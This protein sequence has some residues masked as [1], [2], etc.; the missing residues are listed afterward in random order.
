MKHAAGASKLNDLD[1]E[2]ARIRWLIEQL[3]LDSGC[4]ENAPTT[5]DYPD[6][7]IPFYSQEA[8]PKDA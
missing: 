1:G 8:H 5:E 7:V 6:N 4:P 3:H 2:R